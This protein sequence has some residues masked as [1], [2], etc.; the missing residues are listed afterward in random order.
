[1]FNWSSRNSVTLKPVLCCKRKLWREGQNFSEI[2]WMFLSPSELGF[3]RNVQKAK[4][5]A[6]TYSLCILFPTHQCI[7]EV[8]EPVRWLSSFF[9]AWLHFSQMNFWRPHAY[10]QT[11][12]PIFLHAHLQEKI[13]MSRNWGPQA[14]WKYQRRSHSGQIY[15]CTKLC[16]R[17]SYMPWNAVV[18][19]AAV[20]QKPMIVAKSLWTNA[21]HDNTATGPLNGWQ[22]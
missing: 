2:D 21:H 4:V 8:L 3:L 14:V 11:T 12:S 1:M 13:R 19:A 6:V 17:Q 10:F 18:S 16:W 9:Y 20:I 7:Q 22:L 5:S 15:V